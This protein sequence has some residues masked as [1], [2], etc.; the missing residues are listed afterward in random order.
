MAERERDHGGGE[1]NKMFCGDDERDVSR[2][3]FWSGCKLLTVR[4]AFFL[5]SL[6]SKGDAPSHHPVFGPMAHLFGI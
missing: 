3:R 1:G 2:S 5:T 6:P 4:T